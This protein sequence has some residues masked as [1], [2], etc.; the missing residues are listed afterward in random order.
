MPPNAIRDR[1]QFGDNAIADRVLFLGEKSAT[2]NHETLRKAKEMEAQGV[3]PEEIHA[4]TGWW[5]GVK[6]GRWNYEISDEAFTATRP[7]SGKG[8]FF[9][10][11]SHP[12]LQGSYPELEQRLRVDN[13]DSRLG[14]A[15]G[16][17]DAD[18]VLLNRNTFRLGPA[19]DYAR[20]KKVP[21]EKDQ[22]TS[23]AL[24]EL[25]HAIDLEEGYKYEG[26]VPYRNRIMELRAYDVER[27]RHLLP[28]ERAQT[29]PWKPTPAELAEQAQQEEEYRQF[30]EF[31][32]QNL[33]ER[34]RK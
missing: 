23:T 4:A 25:Q 11:F 31:E 16:A 33:R 19:S 10:H 30:R 22:L 5:K 17:V 13:N 3:T 8:R 6:S 27:R 7:L 24:H 15:L 26:Q 12:G 32:A 18:T 34:R 9:D 28:Q 29:P 20:L 21:V 14:T 1:R 2:A